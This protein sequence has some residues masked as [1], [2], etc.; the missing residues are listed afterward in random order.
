MEFVYSEGVIRSLQHNMMMECG[1]LEKER[2]ILKAV[3][4]RIKLQRAGVK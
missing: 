1:K 3:V 4:E 2:K